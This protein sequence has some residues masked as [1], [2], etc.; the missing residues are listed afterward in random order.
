MEYGVGLGRWDRGAC[1][2]ACPT[3]PETLLPGVAQTVRVTSFLHG[4]LS[5]VLPGS[6]LRFGDAWPWLLLSPKIAGWNLLWPFLF[7]PIFSLVYLVLSRVR[8]A[9]LSFEQAVFQR[10]N[11]TPP[12]RALHQS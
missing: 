10:S 9:R 2:P 8:P 6:G 3:V 4:Q 1:M 7:Q 5:L 11:Q 12:A